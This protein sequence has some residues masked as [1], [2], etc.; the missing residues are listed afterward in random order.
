MQEHYFAKR[1]NV[2]GEPATFL[3]GSGAYMF[4]TC[5]RAYLDMVGVLPAL[6]WYMTMASA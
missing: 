6:A 1:M 4:D 2:R 3:R 5:G